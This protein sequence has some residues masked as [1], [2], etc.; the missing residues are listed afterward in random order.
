MPVIFS[1]R[2]PKV[3]LR[4]INNGKQDRA[5]A[6]LQAIPEEQRTPGEQLLYALAIIAKPDWSTPSRMEDLR[7]GISLIH[8]AQKAL[9]RKDPDQ[10]GLASQ[11]DYLLGLG[12]FQLGEYE[13][14]IPYFQHAPELGAHMSNQEMIEKCC[15]VRDRPK[16]RE[17]F[18]VRTKKAWAA[19]VPEEA[20]LR[21]MINEAVSDKKVWDKMVRK[22]SALFHIA[23]RD[24]GWSWWAGDVPG[25][26]LLTGRN[27]CIALADQ[28]FLAAAPKELEGRWAFQTGTSSPDDEDLEWI[29]EEQDW[30][31]DSDVQI[32]QDPSGMLK[33]VLYHPSLHVERNCSEDAKKVYEAI[34]E[35]IGDLVYLSLIDSVSFSSTPL[36]GGTVKL[37]Q[38]LPALESMGYVDRQDIQSLVLRRHPYTRTPHAHKPKEERRWRDD[39]IRGSSMDLV[40]IDRYHEEIAEYGPAQALAGS[41]VVPCFASGARQTRLPP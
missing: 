19:F 23:F 3:L 13:N 29:R 33:L 40:L 25:I 7:Q 38:L 12:Y 11:G 15:N 21:K 37:W 41:G 32:E 26:I 35:S 4:W 24:V 16:D 28:Y 6:R 9:N 14:A 34:S 18:R 36:G 8:S 5:I 30:L 20:H 10:A 22:V 1:S 17:S 2:N 31:S 27:K 39:V